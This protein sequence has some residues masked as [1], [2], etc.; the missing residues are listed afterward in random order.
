MLILTRRPNERLM[1]GDEITVTVIGIK[2][3]QVRLGVEAP[4]EMPVHREEIYK[5]IQLEKQNEHISEDHNLRQ[6]GE[7]PGDEVH[8]ERDADNDVFG[9]HV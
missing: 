7:G 4:A 8:G 1:I 6:S 9:G 5:R 2:G 3:N